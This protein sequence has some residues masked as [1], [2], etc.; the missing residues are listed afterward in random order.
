M[1]DQSAG[2]EKNKVFV[3]GLP[4]ETNQ[5][6]LYELVKPCGRIVEAK[7]ILDRETGRS[8]GFAFVEMS[9]ASEAQ[10]VIRRLNGSDV[11]GRKLFATEFKTKGKPG[12]LRPRAPSTFSP[13]AVPGPPGGVE[14]RSGK[15]RRK[16]PGF[17][18]PSPERREFKKPW[19][20]RPWSKDKPGSEAGRPWEKK[21]RD[22][23]RKPAFGDRKPWRKD[24]GPGGKKPWG[25]KPFGSRRP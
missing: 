4:W 13:R 1:A 16:N 9:N 20:K 6:E 7:I 3:A 24:K 19:E 18:G 12:G 22:R 15:D 11:G 10:A 25:K 5:H 8:K 21:P 17:G 14:R 2:S 23:D